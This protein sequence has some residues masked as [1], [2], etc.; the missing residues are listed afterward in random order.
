MTLLIV[1]VMALPELKYDYTH[2]IDKSTLLFGVTG[3][4]KSIIIVDIL[5]KLQGHIDQALVISPMDRQNHTYDQGIIPPPCIHYEITSELLTNM[6]ERQVAL[7]N[8]YTRANDPAIIDTLFRL[9]NN[10]NAVRFIAAAKEKSEQHQAQIRMAGGNDVSTKIASVELKCKTVISSIMKRTITENRKTLERMGLDDDHMFSLKYLNLNPKLVLILDDCTDMLMK[11]K[12]HPV[13]Q[14][15]FYQ[16]RWAH[17][18]F[19]IA[20]HTDKALSPELKKNA[21]INIFAEP[22][23]ANSYIERKTNDLDKGS[24][25]NAKQAIDCAFTP[26]AKY[27]KLALIREDKSYYRFTAELHPAFKFG[28]E[29]IWKFCDKITVDAN[30]AVSTNRFIQKFVV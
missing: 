1:S 30:N 6:W 20:C 7:V 2:F 29:M 4:G 23:S 19:L 13:V 15:L 22:T 5:H 11:F 26:L 28:S 17:I 12:S 9:C 24:K 18:T 14:K 27:Q 16:G 25:I 10:S 3:S 8:V 21:F